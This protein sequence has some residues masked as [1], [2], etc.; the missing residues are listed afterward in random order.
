M[1]LTGFWRMFQKFFVAIYY[2]KVLDLNSCLAHHSCLQAW[3][4]QDSARSERTFV[5]NFVQLIMGEKKFPRLFWFVISWLL[6]TFKLTH[7]YAKWSIH[8]TIQHAWLSIRLYNLRARHK[9]NWTNKHY[10]KNYQR[11]IYRQRTIFFIAN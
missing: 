11:D 10:I 8:A 1:L 7:D 2:D 9:A 4:Y 6:F 5:V 3:A